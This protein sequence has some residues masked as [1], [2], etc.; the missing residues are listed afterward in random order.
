[1]KSINASDS[2]GK[3]PVLLGTLATL[4][5]GIMG[6]VASKFW[7][8][9]D[10]IYLLSSIII[11]LL[12]FKIFPENGMILSRLTAVMPV[13]GVTS[14]FIYMWIYH[15]FRV[16][17]NALRNLGWTDYFILITGTCIV[18]PVFEELVVR[19]L[20]F[21][22][23]CRWFRGSFEWLGVFFGALAVSFLFAM[24]H[25]GMVVYAFIFSIVMCFMAW[26]GVHT[27][28]RSIFHGVHNLIVIIFSLNLFSWT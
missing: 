23:V 14:A 27:I 10:A 20:L 13:F 24:V 7:P 6:S 28:N 21:L 22:G 12:L 8:H 17:N 5:L 19:R 26:K 1:M 16:A 15:D 11:S 9:A 3:Y 25:H 18:T 4:V 2:S